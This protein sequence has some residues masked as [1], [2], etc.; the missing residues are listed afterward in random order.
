MFVCLPASWLWP[1]YRQNPGMQN[2]GWSGP[3]Q[4]WRAGSPP[5]GRSS[6]GIWP[7]G[8]LHA[9]PSPQ[10]CCTQQP[11]GSIKAEGVFLFVLFV[12]RTI[13]VFN[14]SSNFSDWSWKWL[15]C[16]TLYCSDLEAEIRKHY[17][18]GDCTL[19]S[20]FQCWGSTMVLVPHVLFWLLISS[21]CFLVDHKV[22]KIKNINKKS[23]S[24]R[25]SVLSG[26]N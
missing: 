26:R 25:V 4:R 21:C 12:V 8:E 14:K 20:C 1:A 2:T 15:W 6:P 10:R 13:N 3:H 16:E 22:I 17:R 11:E 19:V 24:A 5:P 7:L 18:K 23:P 9:S